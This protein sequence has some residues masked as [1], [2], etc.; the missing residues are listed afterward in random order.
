MRSIFSKIS[1]ILISIRSW[2][3]KSSRKVRWITLAAVIVIIAIGV[4]AIIQAQ[5]AKAATVSQTPALQTTVARQGSLVL[6]ASGTGTLIAAKTVNIGFKSSGVLTK[7]NVNVGDQVKAGDLLA[8]LDD[9]TQQIQL[10]QAQQALNELTS[11][12]AIAIAQQAVIT[13]QKNLYN[14]QVVFNN[15]AYAHTNQAAIDNA[16]AAYALAQNKVDKAQATYDPVSG[17][18]LNNPNVAQAYQALYNAQ[19]ARDNALINYKTLASKAG[20]QDIA[21]AT[22]NLALAQAKLTEAQNLVT[23]LTGGTVPANATGSGLDQLNQAKIALQTAQNNLANTQLFAPIPGTVMSINNQIGESVGSGTFITIDDL[24]QAQLQI[25]MDQNDWSNIKVGYVANVTFDALPQDTF[26]GKV[27]QVSP[28]LVTI[29]GTSVVEGLVLLDEKQ[30]SGTT[31]QLPLGVSASVDVIAAQ[32]NNVIL[33][34]V[35]AL[36]QLSPGNYAVFVMTGGKPTLRIVTVGL[37]DSTFAEIKTGLK[38]GDV[39]T[40]GIQATTGGSQ[41]TNP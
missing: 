25:Y 15:V 6:R 37:Q 38:A 20:Q 33:V 12:A 2:F 28:Q 4:Y 9:T 41:V 26:T 19:L 10:A 23:V 8:Q 5:Q 3:F 13:A 18:S 24:S 39:V 1:S 14:A 7:L 16:Y 30:S 35:Q 32:A 22:A 17:G 11:P 31:L 36:H 40:T 29:Q 27:T 34:P 21:S